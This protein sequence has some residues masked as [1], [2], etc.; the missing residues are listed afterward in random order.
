MPTEGERCAAPVDDLP[1]WART[2]PLREDDG[3][4]FRSLYEEQVLGLATPEPAP[5]PA[6][7]DLRL[8]TCRACGAPASPHRVPH[9]VEVIIPARVPPRP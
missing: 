2:E 1:T 7:P 8:L 5:Q 9:A 6:R 4:V 3:V